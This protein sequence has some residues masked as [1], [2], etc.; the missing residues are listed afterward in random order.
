MNF[1]LAA[2]AVH[3]EL[4]LKGSADRLLYVLRCVLCYPHARAWHA[5]LNEPL[6]APAV[7]ANPILYRK[8]VRP[9]FSVWWTKAQ[10]LRVLREHFEFVAGRLNHEAFLELCTPGGFM[11]LQFAGQRGMVLQ[12]RCVNDG[13]FS[14]EGELSLVLDSGKANVMAS[15]L[16]CVIMRE[17]SGPRYSMMIGGTQGPDLGADKNI[18]KDMAKALHGL[19]PKALLLFVAQEIAQVWQLHLIRAT[20]NRAHI[21][22]HIDYTLNRSRRPKL[23]Y[24]EF[25]QE[26]GGRRR[27]DGYYDLPLGYI[28]RSNSEI[29]PNKRSL[30]NQRYEMLDRI[31]GDIRTRLSEL[32][33]HGVPHEDIGGTDGRS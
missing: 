10:T 6:M 21:S 27:V 26:S 12:V 31:S 33:N 30:Y 4:S 23:T 13:T 28:R 7:R 32:A 9:Y 20:S 3:P 22:R 25:W 5:W 17:G 8:I 2:K 15:S 24:D 19:R 1:H 16:T 18:I 11:L 14:K 29:K